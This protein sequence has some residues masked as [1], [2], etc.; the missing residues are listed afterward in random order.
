MRVGKEKKHLLEVGI[1]GFATWQLTSQSGPQPSD[2]APK[3]EVFGVG[4]EIRWTIPK[5]RLRFLHRIQP[6]LGAK[7]A[8]QSNN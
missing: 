3:H 1:S 4:P 5:D 6:E 7:N 8:I 2:S